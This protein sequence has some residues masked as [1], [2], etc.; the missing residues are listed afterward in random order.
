MKTKMLIQVKSLLLAVLA[1][2]LS[3][4]FSHTAIA[5]TSASYKTIMQYD[6]ARR[7]TGVI[8]ADPDGAGGLSSPASRNTYHATSGL[9]IRTENGYLDANTNANLK[10]STWQGFTVETQTLYTYDSQARLASQTRASADGTRYVLTQFSYDAQGRTECVAVRMT[11]NTNNNACTPNTKG[12]AGSDRITKFDYDNDYNDNIAIE[13]RGYGTALAQRYAT[14]TYYPTR[15][16]SPRR[17]A[18]LRQSITDANG[19]TTTYE[20]DNVARVNKLTFPD[21]TFERYAYDKNDNRKQLVKRDR[22]VINY[23]YDALNRMIKKDPASVGEKTTY[24]KY[25]N[26]DLQTAAL[27]DNGRGIRHRYTGFGEV[28]AETNNLGISRTTLNVYDRHGNRIGITHPDGQYFTYD[29]DGLDRLINLK[30]DGTSYIAYRLDELGRLISRD[31]GSAG[32]YFGYD[33]I[34]RTSALTHA[35]TSEGFNF[36]ANYTYNPA[37][38]ITKKE[39]RNPRYYYKES[40]SAQGTYQVNELNQYTSVGGKTFAYDLN[41]NLASDGD[42]NYTYDV[43]NRLTSVAGKQNASLRYDTLGRLYQVSNTGTT[44]LYSGDSLVAEYNGS[45]M[46]NR[47][48]FGNGVDQPLVHFAGSSTANPN[49]LFANHQGS[50]VAAANGLGAV[51]YT[52]TYNE[53]GVPSNNNTGRF[54]YTGQLNLPGL[55]LQYYKARIYNPKIGRFLQTDPVGYED[56][57]NLYAYVGNDPLNHVDPDGRIAGKLIKFFRNTV[58]AKG[59]P[60]KGAAD[61]F[62]GIADDLRTLADGQ[63]NVDDVGAVVS[64]VTGLDKKDQAAIRGVATKRVGRHMSPE[65]LAKMKKT[66]RVQEGGGGQTR[67]ADPSDPNTFKNAPDGDVFVEFDVPAN[68]V[69]PHS[70][71]TGRIPGPNSPDARVPGRNPADFEMPSATN[72]NVPKK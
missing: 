50:I 67:V 52:N 14:Y 26:F 62:A 20:Y 11:I 22:N 53:F 57:M 35:F 70:T 43:E 59:D 9:L 64:L 61:T 72:I 49:Y 38:Q 19:N 21:G 32:S 16:G 5:I 71:G 63:L 29:Y 3:W 44:L 2:A 45:T 15:R 68:R 58:E 12:P 48:V 25:D 23:E 18:G 60:I 42:N 66:G 33:P 56:Q 37:S 13:H 36:G 24:F 31:S 41:G 4:T 30:Q 27:F 17:L 55:S 10:P 65:E 34:S 47:Y 28:E 46:T 51:Q 39:I 8:Q 1:I 54:G 40:G 6:A 7:T 69:L